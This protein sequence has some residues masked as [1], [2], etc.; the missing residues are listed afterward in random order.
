[1]KID[2]IKFEDKRI[3]SAWVPIISILEEF[4]PRFDHKYFVGIKKIILFDK[5]YHRHTKIQASARYIPI[6][7]TKNANIEYYLAPYNDL[8]NE[9]K[10]SRMF[11]TY[12]ILRTLFHELYHHRIRGQRI[13][14]QPKFKQEQNNA[15]QWAVNIINPIFLKSFP[16]EKYKPEWDLIQKI[17]MESINETKSNKSIKATGNRPVAF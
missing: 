17:I 16:R 4:M 15:D 3:D 1:M 13:L 12:E 2:K 11:L 14:R 7:G 10:K 5:D 8:P 6:E 9:A